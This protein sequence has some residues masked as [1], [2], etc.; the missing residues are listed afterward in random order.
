MPWRDQPAY[1]KVTIYYYPSLSPHP[2]L[3]VYELVDDAL[4]STGFVWDRE[5]Q[6][7]MDFEL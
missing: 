4:A 3:Q 6:V 2:S 5:L 7:M 1:E